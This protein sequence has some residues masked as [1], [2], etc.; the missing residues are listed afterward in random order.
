MQAAPISERLS[1]AVN[2]VTQTSVTQTTAQPSR[3]PRWFSLQ[4]IFLTASVVIAVVMAVALWWVPVGPRSVAAAPLKLEDIPFDGTQSYKYLQEICNIGR[5][6]SG[7]EGMQKQQALLTKHF[8]DLGGK[9]ERQ[10]FRVRHPLD[11]SAV[12]M[13]NLIVHW[14]PERKERILLCAHYDTR[15]FPDQDPREPRGLFIGANDGGSGVALL[16]E[17]GKHMAD[18]DSKYGVDFVLFD[19]EELVFGQTGTY[20]LGSEYFA[21]QYIRNRPDYRYAAAVLID[22]VADANLRIYQEGHSVSWPESRP[23]V[24]DIWRVA[25]G[26]GVVEFVAR[27]KH[28]VRD[29]HLPLRNTARIPSCDIIDFDYP[30]WHTVGDTPD[31]CSPLSLAKVGWVVH[32]WLKQL[33]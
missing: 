29:D 19:G 20:F 15:P 24:E 27:A 14:H 3:Q 6:V 9:V 8:T 11:G 12:D 21:Q 1:P 2:S 17:L 33:K 30:Y 4:W 31:K 25:R 22:M 28:T 16:M 13:A 5:R 7:T 23:M 26:L 18:Y 32:E 10:E